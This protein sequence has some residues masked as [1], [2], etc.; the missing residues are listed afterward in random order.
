MIPSIVCYVDPSNVEERSKIVSHLYREGYAPFI[1]TNLPSAMNLEALRGMV[2]DEELKGYVVSIKD[3]LT[4]NVEPAFIVYYGA[5]TDDTLS[6]S[7]YE[8]LIKYFEALFK[9]EEYK[10]DSYNG[11]LAEYTKPMTKDKRMQE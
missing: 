5:S 3:N 11:L 6:V 7:D 1:S 8:T 2:F 4:C 10:F 9:C